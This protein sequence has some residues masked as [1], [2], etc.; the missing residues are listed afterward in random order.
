MASMTKLMT[1][2]AVLQCVEQGKLD[3]DDDVRSLLPEMGKYGIITGFEDEKNLATF[4]ADHTPISLRMLLCHIS[5]QEYDRLNPLL[6]KWRA[7][8]NEIPWSGPL[9]TDKSAIP[10]GPV[11]FLDIKEWGSR[12]VFGVRRV[13][14]VGHVP[15][16][17][18][19]VSRRI[20]LASLDS[21]GLKST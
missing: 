1:S 8:R 17:S 2:V 12:V 11:S 7:S 16:G 15:K 14:A 19:V 10:R 20:A 13:A 5:G 18:K 21:P 3:L 6:G 4:E 9:L